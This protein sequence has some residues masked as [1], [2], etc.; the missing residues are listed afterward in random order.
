MIFL[1]MQ[2]ACEPFVER[3]FHEIGLIENI[4]DRKRKIDVSKLSLVSK[5]HFK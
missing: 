2:K 5:L 4:A 1:V 3:G